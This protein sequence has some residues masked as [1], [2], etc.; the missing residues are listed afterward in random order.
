MSGHVDALILGFG[1]AAV[2]LSAWLAGRMGLV[3]REGLP[4]HAA[5]RFVPYSF[6]LLRE[7]VASNLAVGRII[8]SEKAEIDPSIVEIPDGQRTDV[9]RALY[10]NS[11]T[12]TPGTVT[13]ESDGEVLRV[14]ALTRAAADDLR[15]GVMERK[16]AAVD[17][18]GAA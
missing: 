13:V 1:L 4:L 16:V 7:I 17:G 14:H 5:V 3:D 15:S 12:L 10:G 2:G 8:L 18:G 11:I 6:W 9:G